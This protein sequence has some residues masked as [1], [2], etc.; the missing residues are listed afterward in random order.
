METKHFVDVLLSYGNIGNDSRSALIFSFTFI[1][2]SVFS[3][4]FSCVLMQNRDLLAKKTSETKCETFNS[5]NFIP[6]FGKPKECI[7]IFILLLRG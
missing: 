2:I 5:W 4:G 6:S 7:H 3:F 1:E